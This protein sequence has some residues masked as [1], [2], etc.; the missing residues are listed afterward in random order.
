MSE[1]FKRGYRER[2]SFCTKEELIAL[3]EVLEKAIAERARVNPEWLEIGGEITTEEKKKRM[4]VAEAGRKGG[5]KTAETH[6]KEFYQE[7]GR[8]G[9]SKVS[10]E[11][12][13]EFYSEIGHKGGSA[14]KK[15]SSE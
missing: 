15:N 12:G 5:L 11:F 8:K 7:I 6:G 4:T 13:P 2:F 14:K 10:K 1:G 9:G 3:R